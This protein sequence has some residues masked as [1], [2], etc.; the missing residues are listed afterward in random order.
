VTVEE[1]KHFRSDENR[2]FENH[3]S[4]RTKARDFWGF[5]LKK[6]LCIGEMDR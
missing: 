5:C 2:P 3:A 4:W 1:E 6:Q